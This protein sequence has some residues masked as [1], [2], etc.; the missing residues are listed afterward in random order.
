MKK[1]QIIVL[2]ILLPVCISCKQKVV[3]CLDVKHTEEKRI[4][5]QSLSDSI[6]HEQ[7]NRNYKKAEKMAL[8]AIKQYPC[9]ATFYSSLGITY[10]LGYKDYNKAENYL[11]LAIEVNP[12]HT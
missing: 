10:Q 6:W 7:E 12:N 9:E 8:D 4:M 5:L 3:P 2:I 1:S 11:R